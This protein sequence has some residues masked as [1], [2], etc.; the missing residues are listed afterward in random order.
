MSTVEQPN[1][2]EESEKKF[3]LDRYLD[4]RGRWS[5]EFTT[6]DK[7]KNKI[8]FFG[9][10]VCT[11][12]LASLIWSDKNHVK[13]FKR[14]RELDESSKNTEIDKM[15]VHN[16]PMADDIGCDFKDAKFLFARWCKSKDAK[17]KRDMEKFFESLC[18]KDIQQMPYVRAVLAHH[19]DYRRE[20][21]HTIQYYNTLPEKELFLQK[22]PKNIRLF[23]QLQ[24]LVDSTERSSEEN[25]SQ[26]NSAF[27]AKH[28]SVI[29]DVIF[30]EK[31]FHEHYVEKVGFEPSKLIL[32][33]S[34]K[35]I[36]KQQDSTTNEKEISCNNDDDNVEEEEEEHDDDDDNE[37]KEEEH[38]DDDVHNKKKKQK[39]V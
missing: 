5:C 37:E 27:F 21:L 6:W 31:R 18:W 36:E 35:L 7:K 3:I 26:V 12:S 25:V 28:F 24:N 16:Y 4:D 22:Y 15:I 23:E 30:S 8:I 39:K 34:G 14:K 17:A 11:S 1:S 13:N 38:D 19:S 32:S 9:H 29:K 20:F 33:T 2:L 10:A